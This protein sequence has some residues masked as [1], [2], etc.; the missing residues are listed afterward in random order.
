M[1]NLPLTDTLKQKGNQRELHVVYLSSVLF[2]HTCTKLISL[3]LLNKLMQIQSRFVCNCLKFS[4]P[5]LCLDEAQSFYNIILYIFTLL[6]PFVFLSEKKCY[7]TVSHRI[8][9]FFLVNT[10]KYHVL[11][12]HKQK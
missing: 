6:I 2:L 5:S 9:E 3:S 11:I 7:S 8:Q 4:Q 1:A 12:D 10:A